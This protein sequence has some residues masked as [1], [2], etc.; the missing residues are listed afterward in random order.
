MTRVK[1]ELTPEQ[2]NGIMFAL[3][4][5]AN[6]LLGEM[7]GHPTLESRAQ[8]VRESADIYDFACLVRAAIRDGA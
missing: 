8:C 7:D 5:Y 4:N 2:A 1:L 6:S 3:E